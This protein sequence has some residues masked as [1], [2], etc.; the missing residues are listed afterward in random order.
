M[1]IRTSLVSILI[2]SLLTSAMGQK[3]SL[4]Q[5]QT[6]QPADQDE[7][8]R[9]TTNL[10][11]IDAVVTDKNGKHV[12]DLRPEDFEI[13]VNGKPQ[14]I[15]NFSLVT[16]ESQKTRQPATSNQSAIKNA[17]LPLPSAPLRPEQVQRTLALI[18]DDLT[19][20]FESMHFVR[21]ALKKFVD[22]QMQ[23]GDLVAIV[24]VGS[25]IGALQQFTTDKAQLHAAIDRVKYNPLVGRTSAFAPFGSE[26]FQG[27]GNPSQE[28][29][30]SLRANDNPRLFR[31]D[32]M[33]RSS[34]QATSYVVQGMRGLPGRKAVLVLSEGFL[35]NESTKEHIRRIV[36]SAN[37][38]AVTVHTM[39]ARGLQPLGLT[40]A[41]D[42]GLPIN[43]ANLT[44]R[45]A[46][47]GQQI[48]ASLERRRIHLINTQDGLNYLAEQTGGFAIRNT[49]DL[50]SGIR[51]A[52]DDQTNYYLLG[53]QPEASTFDTAKSRF[54]RLTIKVKASG[55]KVRYR[56]GFFG[57]TDEEAAPVAVSPREQIVRALSSPFAAGEIS[58][59][60]TALW[61][62]DAQAG[63]FLRSLVHI[64]AKDLTFTQKADGSH[65]A[66]VNIVAYVFGDNG[67]VVDSVGETH[68][69][70]LTDKLYKRALSSG[71][72]YS[73]NVLLKR[74]G[75]YQLRVAV[76]DNKSDR[77]GSASQFV[78]VPD[79]RK[80]RLSLSG[81]AL[82]SDEPQDNNKAGDNN[83]QSPAETTGNSLLTQAALR[84][85]NTGRILQFAYTVYNAKTDT[86][87]AQP[88]LTTQIKL[89]R[90]GKEIFA[91]KETPYDAGQQRDLRR[92][93]VEGA[94]QLGGLAA[95]DYVLQVIV[96]DALAKEK[97]RRTTGWVDF[98]VVK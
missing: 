27:G 84:R 39:D 32:L 12:A 52:L 89:Y 28:E 36:D 76:H 58:L 60:L 37:R 69:V 10:V 30:R 87:T 59:R 83:K 72:V 64:P 96:T 70:T 54:N 55:L 44:G 74:A 50:S 68:T 80:E 71:F 62:N 94:L 57:M 5:Q 88:K 17:P 41:D 24:R 40:A 97:A 48:Q 92:L 26:D 34:L 63:S 4:T 82:S 8:V 81:I 22:E 75:A 16:T 56:S 65:E 47:S 45:R 25:S 29:D 91:G 61:G 23:P 19:L 1:K 20:S 42:I 18:V 98:E 43:A 9:I 38:S 51:T 66:L 35:L 86:Q 77:I 49:N 33:A 7:V 3:P 93:V 2:L 31:D 73:L 15:T 95:G 21:R 78:D 11:Q 79:L 46:M 53:F 90:D 85:F 14:R 67:I 6:V 13:L